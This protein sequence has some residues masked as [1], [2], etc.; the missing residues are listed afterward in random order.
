MIKKSPAQLADEKHIWHPFT[1]LKYAETPVNII[2]S[3]GAHY[4][5]E[6]GYKYIDAISSWWVNLHGHSHMYIADKVF[7]Q[8]KNNAHSIFSG[9]THPAAI[10]LGERLIEKLPDNFSKVFFSDDGSTSVEVA[11]K[12]AL[13]Y[14][15]NTGVAKTKIIAFE[16][17]YHGDTFGSMSVGARN[18]FTNAFSPLLFDVLRIPVPT[19]EN[20][21][22]VKRE[23]K[24]YVKEGDICAFIFEPLILGAGGMQMYDAKHL[25]EL[26]LICRNEKIICIADEV[27]TGF[28]RT[29][30]FFATDHLENKP[31]I[32]CLSKGI[33]GGV[34]PLGVTACAEFIYDA[35][36][37]DDKNKTFFH[38]HSY[39]ANPTACAAANASLDLMDRKET[40]A[41]IKRIAGQHSIFAEKI[42]FHEKVKD[43]RCLGTI[44]ALEIKNPE[45]TGYMNS[46]SEKI[47]SW[48]LE[49]GIILRPLGN[50]LYILPPY[51]IS[52]DDLSYIYS[53]IETFLEHELK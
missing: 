39:T 25:D 28:G 15:N 1:H 47:S 17:A 48:F 38:G 20:F 14:W 7:Q 4:F 5:D 26:I 21:D 22:A 16:D 23:L 9:F 46:L 50:V 32:I 42:K 44:L 18:V 31:D 49:Q 10:E 19:E 3:Q 37:S 6:N 24:S 43:A 40:F 41:N 51:C 27:M 33:T 35:Y 13:Q 29:G 30:K 11:L 45:K 34:M 53:N 8:L 52:N 2:G 36:V 12:M